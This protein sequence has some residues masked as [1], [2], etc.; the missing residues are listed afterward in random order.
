M[1]L[2][3]P[4]FGGGR[5]LFRASGGPF[6]SRYYPTRHA[7]SP[8]VFFECRSRP[9]RPVRECHSVLPLEQQS[10]SSVFVLHFL[11]VTPLFGTR[12]EGPLGFP[13]VRLLLPPSSHTDFSSSSRRNPLPLVLPEGPSLHSLHSLGQT[14]GGLVSSDPP[15]LDPYFCVLGRQGEGGGREGDGGCVLVGTL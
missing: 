7:V 11:L 10:V 5:G 1:S 13:I 6:V 8:P 14:T 2:R 9:D 4:L 12:R 3:F 15:S